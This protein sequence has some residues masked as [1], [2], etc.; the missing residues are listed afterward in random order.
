MRIPDFQSRATFSLEQEGRVLKVGHYLIIGER[1]TSILK[2]LWNEH[3]FTLPSI[4]SS[5][6]L[7]GF[8]CQRILVLLP[9]WKSLESFLA[10]SH[11]NKR[12][13]IVGWVS[14][15]WAGRSEQAIAYYTLCPKWVD[16][17]LLQQHKSSSDVQWTC[18]NAHRAG[19]GEEH[20]GSGTKPPSRNLCFCS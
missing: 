1:Q 13:P 7:E 6:S 2:L 9:M 10:H 17:V 19:D 11:K 18:P 4:F 14:M 20:W 12:R 16:F 15:S 8:K 3:I 5:I